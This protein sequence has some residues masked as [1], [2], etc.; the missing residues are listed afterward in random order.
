MSSLVTS[1][2]GGYRGYFLEA[3]AINM[4]NK[5]DQQS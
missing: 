1:T 2:V 5:T 3:L 4:L